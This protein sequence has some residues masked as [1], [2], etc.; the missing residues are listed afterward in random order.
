[1]RGS[2]IGGSGGAGGALFYRAG[3]GSSNELETIASERL[4]GRAQQ[5]C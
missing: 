1:L 2:D 4:F 5:F 3:S